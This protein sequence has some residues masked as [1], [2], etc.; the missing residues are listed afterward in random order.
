MLKSNSDKSGKIATKEESIQTILKHAKIKNFE[1]C[2]S[3]N[4]IYQVDPA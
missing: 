1:S 3:V 4:Q 2:T